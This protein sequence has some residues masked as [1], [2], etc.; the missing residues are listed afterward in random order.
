MLWIMMVTSIPLA[1][2]GEPGY[3]DE[4]GRAFNRGVK[5]V[6]SAPWEIPYTIGQY[7]QKNDG[8]S[9]FFRETAGLFDGIFRTLTR[10]GCGAWDML[11]A[12][13]PGEQDGLPL[14]PETFF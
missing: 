2:A 4:L 1:P 9:I 3:F 5:N 13:V 10:F 12:F 7:D 11:W 14:K 6:V 8:N